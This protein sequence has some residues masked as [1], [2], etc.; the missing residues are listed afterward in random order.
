MHEKKIKGDIAV[1][2]AIAKLTLL[3]WN[4]GVLITEHA[5]YDLLVEKA[6]ELCR[7]QVRHAVLHGDVLIIELGN[8]WSSRLGNHV[9][10]RDPDAYEILAAH[11]SENGQ[12]YFLRKEQINPNTRQIRLRLAPCLNGQLRR[13]RP[14]KDYLAV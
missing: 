8:S 4:V 13:I 14:A 7:V 2:A 9:K 11:S 1:T 12:T 5:P 6:G 10:R 3:G